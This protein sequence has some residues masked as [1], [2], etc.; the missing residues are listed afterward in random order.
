VRILEEHSNQEPEITTNKSQTLK[1][2]PTTTY[3]KSGFLKT[4][5]ELLLLGLLFVSILY[6]VIL[7][8]SKSRKN[9]SSTPQQRTLHQKSTNPLEFRL[10]EEYQKNKKLQQH[11]TDLQQKLE[12]IRL[13]APQA[14]SIPVK[15]DTVDYEWKNNDVKDTSTGTNQIN[16][17][18][19]P[20]N[21]FFISAPVSDLKFSISEKQTEE[22]NEPY[23]RFEGEEKGSFQLNTNGK[24]DFEVLLNSPDLYLRSA[25]EYA[26]NPKSDH[27]RI[28]NVTAGKFEV[29]GNDIIVLQKTKIKFV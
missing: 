11:I 13:T 12:N 4:W 9:K 29:R 20:S 3:I 14:L 10:K 28:E 21:F 5:Q 6:S 8:A 24:I 1:S 27:V 18:V 2:K 26:N 7:K 25:A 19:K 23:Y 15:E 22:K 17:P 16:Q